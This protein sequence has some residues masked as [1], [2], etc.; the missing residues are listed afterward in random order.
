MMA[1]LLRLAMGEWHKIRTR[2]MPWILLGLLVLITQ[3]ALWLSYWGYHSGGDPADLIE[4]QQQFTLPYSLTGMAEGYIAFFAIPLLILSASLMGMEYGWGTLRSTIVRGV[5]RWQLV[6]GKLIMLLCAAI[7]GVLI[8]AVLVGIASLI[9][10]A[11]PPGE[12]GPPIVGDGGEWLRAILGLLK[13]VYTLVP[14]A[15]LGVFLALL[16]QST[17]QGIAMSIIYYVVDLLVFPALGAI[18]DWLGTVVDVAALGT[19]VVALMAAGNGTSTE[20]SDTVRAFFVL[21]AYIVVLTAAAMWLFQRRDISG[22][23][24]E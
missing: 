17:A 12:E 18:T 10:G 22:A 6:G 19:N 16:T 14:Y 8:A 9:A 21:L 1:H 11:I 20:Q 4:S 2:R 15:A 3:G 5:G 13:L 23:R 24:G 7:A